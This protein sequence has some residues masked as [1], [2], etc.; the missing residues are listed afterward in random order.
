MSVFSKRNDR[1]NNSYVSQRANGPQSF[2]RSGYNG[3]NA[4]HL[5]GNYNRPHYNDQNNFMGQQYGRSVNQYG[6]QTNDNVHGSPSYAGNNYQQNYNSFQREN[7]RQ[8]HGNYARPAMMNGKN[9]NQADC[10][11]S[12][13]T[14]S[15]TKDSCGSSCVE[16]V[17]LGKQYS[18]PV[19]KE[20][21]LGS[22]QPSGSGRRATNYS[23][24]LTESTMD[25]DYVEPR[26]VFGQTAP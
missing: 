16:Q 18:M 15:T 26:R 3:N 11:S 7:G 19:C 9:E 5:N 21:N 25:R 10:G 20:V 13:Y 24:T 8:N 2:M 17:D 1:Q 12:V 22:A 4:F 14:N 23:N 6:R